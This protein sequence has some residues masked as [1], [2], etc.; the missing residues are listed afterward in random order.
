MLIVGLTGG[1][2][3][4]KST[5]ARLLAQHGAA[6]LDVDAIGRQVLE[7]GHQAAE[8]VLREFG[9][10]V[11]GADGS[12][13]RSMLARTVF[14]DPDALARLVAISHPAINDE[15]AAVMRSL[16]SNSIVILDIAVL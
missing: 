5:V 9:S 11:L 6:V 13:D 12:I 16:P 3:A 8:R 7:P 14:S 1:M 10:D 15:L 2:G 4:G